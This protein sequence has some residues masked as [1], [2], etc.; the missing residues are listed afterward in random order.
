MK[1]DKV[2][3]IVMSAAVMASVAAAPVWAEV[4]EEFGEVGEERTA[5]RL[6]PG[7]WRRNTGPAGV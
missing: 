2:V 5:G 4:G 7:G 1:K 3:K 6:K